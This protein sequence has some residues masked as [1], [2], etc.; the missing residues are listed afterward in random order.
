MELAGD[1]L[2]AAAMLSLEV[3]RALRTPS[4]AEITALNSKMRRFEGFG[5]RQDAL[6]AERDES[7]WIQE[8]SKALG[9]ADN[10]VDV[11]KDME[12]ELETLQARLEFFRANR[13]QQ[14]VPRSSFRRPEVTMSF[15][16][17]EQATNDRDEQ[18]P[19]PLQ[20][21][22]AGK[23]AD[24]VDSALMECDRLLQRVRTPCTFVMVCI[25]YIPC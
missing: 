6:R 8:A 16:D 11:N 24:Q 15:R 7:K 2:E 17:E 19:K 20:P 22:N 13:S 1:D 21:K 23:V 5:R 18:N 14:H 3:D 4:K 10:V 9:Q 12:L 25:H